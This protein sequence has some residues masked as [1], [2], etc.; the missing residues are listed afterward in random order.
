[1]IGFFI[2]VYYSY[3][4]SIDKMIDGRQ[5]KNIKIGLFVDVVQKH[6]QTSTELTRGVVQKIL[7][8]SPNH[9]YGIKV[10]LTSGLVG[11]V[12]KII[13]ES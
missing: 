4:I 10:Q 5:R 9:P 12:K 7:T 11:R 8:N 2:F 3:L 1:M 13:E 6:H